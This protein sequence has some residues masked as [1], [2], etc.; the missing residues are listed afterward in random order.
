MLFQTPSYVLERLAITVNAHLPSQPSA[1]SDN[2]EPIET[3]HK[4]QRRTR[5]MLKP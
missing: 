4:S 1:C 3:I 2:I 5:H